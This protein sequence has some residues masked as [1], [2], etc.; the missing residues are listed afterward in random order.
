M[1]KNFDQIQKDFYN[2]AEVKRF[3]W[4]TQNE[5]VMEQE[6]KL[7]AFFKGIIK[8]EDSIL[9]VGCGEG[10]N[11]VCLRS[12]GIANQFIGVD[13]CQE[14]VD[15]CTA[16]GIENTTFQQADA[17]NLPFENAQF[18][19]SIARDLL[20]HV[21]ENRRAVIDELMRVTAPGGKVVIVEGNVEKFTNFV[22]ATVYQHEKGMKDSTKKKMETM[23]EG[24][25]YSMKAAEPSNFFRMALHYNI[26]VPGLA[27]LT[28][29][30]KLFD[31]QNALFEFLLPEKYYAYWIVQIEKPEE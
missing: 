14:K 29:F 24:Y 12:M 2:S 18:R 30:R 5:Y 7:L 13:F 3:Y 16:Q 19:I 11:C 21:N 9:E 31:I 4:Q 23:L 20:H 28:V 25:Q 1:A 26:G 22:F 27:K 17:R 10:A 8:P 6:K 15:F